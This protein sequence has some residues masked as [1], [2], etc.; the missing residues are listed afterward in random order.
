MAGTAVGPEQTPPPGPFLRGQ[1]RVT[2]RGCHS[3]GL[4]A[5]AQPGR[6]PGDLK[7][8]GSLY[9]EPIWLSGCRFRVPIG[10]AEA[11]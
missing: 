11:W 6:L 9:Y 10:G 5:R 1:P 3:P 8:A 4:E 7:P 2:S